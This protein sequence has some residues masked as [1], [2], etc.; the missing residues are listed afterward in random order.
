MFYCR[1]C[2]RH[3]TE[4]DVYLIKDKDGRIRVRC[5]DCGE[6]VGDRSV[7]PALSMEVISPPPEGKKEDE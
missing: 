3:L 4:D 7:P 5:D 1:E 2:V 6:E